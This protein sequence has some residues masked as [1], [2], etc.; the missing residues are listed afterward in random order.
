MGSK[1]VYKSRLNPETAVHRG[2][3]LIQVHCRQLSVKGETILIKDSHKGTVPMGVH[4]VMHPP[5]HGSLILRMGRTQPSQGRMREQHPLI[6]L[7]TD[8][9]QTTRASRWETATCHLTVKHLTKVKIY[10][11]WDRPMDQPTLKITYHMQTTAKFKVNT[12]CITQTKGQIR[13]CQ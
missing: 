12:R 1:L 9:V 2:K 11:P 7:R 13:W 5:Q 3:L 6:Y 8:T 4:G 10:I